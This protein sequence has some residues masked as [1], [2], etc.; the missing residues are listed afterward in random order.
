MGDGKSQQKVDLKEVKEK[1]TVARSQLLRGA[2]VFLTEGAFRQRK[3]Y[4]TAKV[5]LAILGM[6]FT[7]VV[8]ASKLHVRAGMRSQNLFMQGTGVLNQ[9]SE[10][11][12]AQEQMLTNP[13]LMSGMMKQNLSGIVPQVNGLACVP[14]CDV[15]AAVIAC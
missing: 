5:G 12:S 1:Q 7:G 6:L 3:A 2:C 10:Q 4:L 15:H 11:K 14:T 8:Y 9:K 13:D